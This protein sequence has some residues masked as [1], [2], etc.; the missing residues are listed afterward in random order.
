MDQ[1][2][3]GNEND[4]GSERH[5]PSNPRA[6]RRAQL[7]MIDAW[8]MPARVIVN[9]PHVDYCLTALMPL[10]NFARTESRE[11]RHST[12]QARTLPVQRTHM[13]K[14]GGGLRHTGEDPLRK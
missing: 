10:V 1:V 6:K 5:H 12:H 8:N 2:G 11:S 13:V 4:R 3:I 14:I 9:R 7:H